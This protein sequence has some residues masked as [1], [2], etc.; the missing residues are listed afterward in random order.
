MA[1]IIA[2]IPIK[3]LAA[4]IKKTIE[5]SGNLAAQDI[6]DCQLDMGW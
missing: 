4:G 1:A 5:R 2:A 3:L 6:I